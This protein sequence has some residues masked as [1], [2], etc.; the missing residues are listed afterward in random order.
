[1]LEHGS[2]AQKRLIAGRAPRMLA[3]F[4]LSKKVCRQKQRTRAHHSSQYG[5]VCMDQRGAVPNE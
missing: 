3:D 5:Q 1:M 4:P 2:T